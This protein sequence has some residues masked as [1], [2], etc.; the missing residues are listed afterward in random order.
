MHPRIALLCLAV[1]ATDAGAQRRIELTA[2]AGCRDC[3]IE[4]SPAV[5]LG[6]DDGDGTIDHSESMVVR[7]S[8]GHFVVAGSYATSLKVFD[9]SGRFIRTVGRD[10]QGPG[11]FRGVGSIDV[12]PGDTLVVFDWGTSRYSL[13]S[14]DYEYLAT[15]PLPLMPERDAVALEDGEFV[16][17]RAIHTAKERGQPLHRVSRDG[18]LA[19]SFGSSSGE[20]RPDVPYQLS[21]AIGRSRGAQMWSA[22]RTSY[23]VDLLDAR[24]GMVV[25]TFVRDVPWF[26]PGIA[27]AP[28]GRAEDLTPKPFIYDVDED[29]SGLLWVLI[30]VPDP[31]WRTAVSSAPPGGHAT[32]TDDHA[33]RDVVIEVIDPARG[34][35]LATTRM[36]ERVTQF[37]GAGMIGTVIEDAGGVPRLRTWTVRLVGATSAA[38]P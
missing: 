26:P 1:L 19:R 16:F 37:I 13:F 8:R 22:L 18:K 2:D 25:R 27:P 17:A 6:D 7:D 14:R 33:Y 35:V 3:R 4:V 30:A 11:E 36:K 5:A 38:P 28:R 21:R 34:V 10:G 15:A 20:F 29:P 24:A 9:R 32:V 31:Q 12:L 23:Q